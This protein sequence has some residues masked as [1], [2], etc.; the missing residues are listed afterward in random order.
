MHH[1]MK[2]NQMS[3]LDFKVMIVMIMISKVNILKE[4]REEKFIS[5]N[6]EEEWYDIWFGYNHMGMFLSNNKLCWLWWL[7]SNKSQLKAQ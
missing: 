3:N 4:R 5:N 1:Q 7:T 6:T 2:D